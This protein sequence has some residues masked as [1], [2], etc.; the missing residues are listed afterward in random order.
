MIPSSENVMK[1]GQSMA[2]GFNKPVL[3]LWGGSVMT[4]YKSRGWEMM[5]QHTNILFFFLFF[6]SVVFLQPEYLE[7]IGMLEGAIY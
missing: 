2:Y 4:A 7:H 6:P 1:N 5:A 3:H